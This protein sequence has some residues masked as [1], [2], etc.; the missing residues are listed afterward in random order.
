[1][2]NF[3]NRKTEILLKYQKQEYFLFH[4]YEKIDSFFVFGLF[5]GLF[6]VFLFFLFVFFLFGFIF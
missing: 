4:F 5:F 3:K 6:L 2:E 1:M